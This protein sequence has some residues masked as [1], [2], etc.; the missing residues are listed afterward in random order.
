VQPIAERFGVELRRPSRLP[1]TRL[2]HEAAAWARTQHR[3]DAFHDEIFRALYLA[4]KDFSEIEV[5]TGIARQLGLNS[6]DLEQALAEHR[7]ADEIDE[8]LL[9]GQTYGIRG[10]PAY[11]I[12]GQ[13]LF[14]VQE[15]SVLVEAIRR[16]ERMEPA[17][18]APALPPVPVNISRK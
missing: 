14:G 11:V 18:E 17:P 6:I 4:D 12:G 7:M 5:L 3:F 13:V 15:E 1:L 9:I 2:A 8:D 10:V 16:A